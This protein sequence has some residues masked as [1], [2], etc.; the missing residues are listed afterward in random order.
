MTTIPRRILEAEAGPPGG[1][2]R[3]WSAS[4]IHAQ[5]ERVTGAKPNK[6]VIKLYNLNDISIQVLQTPGHVIQVRAGEGAVTGAIF[7]GDID[8]NTVKRTRTGRDIVTEISAQDGQRIY[9]DSIFARTYPRNTTRS[10]VLSDLLAEMRIARGYIAPLLERTY[11]TSRVYA[12]PA[13]H[14]LDQLFA[15]DRATWSIQGGALVVLAAGQAAP[16][17]A[18]LISARTGMIGI[19]Q[20]DKAGVKV[21]SFWIPGTFPGMGFEVQSQF[22]GGSFRAV[23]IRDDLDSDGKRWETELTGAKLKAA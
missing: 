19:P 17:N 6:A 1:L 3:L 15:P 4:F 7:T 8:A 14:V 16:G 22:Q 18:P 11:P 10:Q 12:A 21:K 9:R 13:R 2:G 20:R 23:K 5:I